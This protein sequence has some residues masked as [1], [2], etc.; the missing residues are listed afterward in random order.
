[1]AL[2]KRRHSKARRDR[3]RTHWKLRLPSIAVCP[4]C[5]ARMMMHRACGV[6][7]YHKDEKVLK[8]KEAQKT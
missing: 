1:M 6:C 3:R 4:H 5:A 2:P 8:V 7:G